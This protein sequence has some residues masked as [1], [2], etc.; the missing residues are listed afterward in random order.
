MNGFRKVLHSKIHRATVTEANLEY[1]GSITLPPD[2]LEAANFAEFEAVWVWNISNGNRFETYT[3]RGKSNNGGIC[4]NGAAAHLI[5]PGDKVIIASFAMLPEY[6]LREH[7]PT[8]VFVD[9]K[10]SI[11][12][13]RPE[14]VSDTDQSRV[15]TL[16]AK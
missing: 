11:K 16:G 6:S 3:I 12:E 10:N 5:T 15:L 14:I 2:L 1:E 7:R 9:E 4:V 8:V 13:I